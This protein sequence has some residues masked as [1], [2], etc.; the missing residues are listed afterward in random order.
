MEDSEIIALATED[1]ENTLGKNISIIILRNKAMKALKS[2]KHFNELE[3]E[4]LEKIIDTFRIK[5]AS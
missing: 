2:S 5:R 4:Y 3:S 1:I